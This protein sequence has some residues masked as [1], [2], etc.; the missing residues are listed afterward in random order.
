MKQFFLILISLNLTACGVYQAFDPCPHRLQSGDCY[1]APRQAVDDPDLVLLT[2]QAAN[3]LLQ[4]LNTPMDKHKAMLVTSLANVNRLEETS[5]L[6]RVLGEQLAAHF[7]KQGY[8]VREARFRQDL[9]I[10]PNNGE[11]ILSRSLP[12]I[13]QHQAVASVTTGTYAVGHTEVY[14]TLKVLNLDGV[15]LASHLMTLPLGENMRRLLGEG[16]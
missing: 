2:Q 5:A 15:V 12:K 14:V 1:H 13:Y 7:T 16:N 8:T 6:G 11:F 4:A 9:F 10:E 3:A